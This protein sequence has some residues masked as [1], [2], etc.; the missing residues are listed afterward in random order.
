MY[1]YILQATVGLVSY[2][3]TGPS[4]RYLTVMASNR[5]EIIGCRAINSKQNSKENG[6][7][8]FKIPKSSLTKWQELSPSSQLIS[9][10]LVCTRHFDENDILKGV[11]MADGFHPYRRWL[12]RPGANPKHFLIPS[13]LS[14]S[15]VIVI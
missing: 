3:T 9:K 14:Y 12:L 8:F 11:Q 4:T 15:C 5:C 6:V 10:S 1:Y 7:T 2:G 13:K